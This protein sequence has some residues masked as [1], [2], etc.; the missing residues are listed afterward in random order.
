METLLQDLR[1][2]LRNMG[3][4]RAFTAI[5]ILVLALGIG[6]NTAMFSV[7]HGVLLRPLPFPQ[8]ERLLAVGEVDVRPQRGGVGITASYPD[9]FDFRQRTRTIDNLAA[10]HDS[11]YTLTGR[12]DPRHLPGEVVTSGFF[13]ALGVRPQLGRTF[14]REEEQAGRHVAILS[15]TLWRSQFNADPAIVGQAINLGERPYTVVGVMP[16][17]FQFPIHAEAI[18]LWTSIAREAESDTADKPVTTER[19]AHFLQMIGRLK[20]GVSPEQAQADMDSIARALAQQYPDENRY[21]TRTLL[22][23]VLTAIVG[24]R[25][26]PLLVLLGAVGLVLLIACANVANLLLARSTARGREIAIRAALGAT[27]GRIIRQLVTESVALALAGATLGT[28][29]AVWALAALVRLYP[30]NLPRLQQVNVDVPVL[31]FTVALALATGILFGLA[32]ALRV[33]RPDVAAAM[34]DGGRVSSSVQHNRLRSALVVAQTALGLMLLVGA[35]LLTRSFTRLTHVDPGL[36]THNVV[37]A[38]FGLPARYS[39]SEQQDQFVRTLFE[40]LNHLSGV[41]SAAGIMPLPLG[42]DFWQI[43]FEVEGRPLPPSEHLSAAFATATPGAFETLHIPLLRGR[44]FNER[45]QRTAPLVMIVNQAFAKLYYPGEDPIGKRL[46]PG[47][48]DGGPEPWR[49]IVGV[50][51]DVRSTGM[52]REP[53]P[54]YYLPYS[55]CVVNTPTIVLR[56]TGD[57]TTALAAARNVMHELD[58]QVALY[59]T[60][61]MEDYVALSVGQAKFQTVLF[62][63]F[64]AIALLLTAV[65]L[66]GVIAYTVVQ[67][68]HEIGIRMALGASR[69]HVLGLMMQ[70]GALLVG[71]GLAVGLAGALGLTRFLQSMLFA[72]HPEDPLTIVAVCSLLAVIALLASYIP[73]RRATKVDPLVTLRYE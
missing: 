26:T 59:G 65:G 34:K 10:Y 39:K 38:D 61:T 50:V 32:P 6:A 18:A 42:G 35:G 68:T 11:D 53:K 71:I 1:F 54:G 24:D 28:A 33:S 72:T 29:L 64:A 48:S 22:Q 40:R 23:P 46:K 49:E 70:H 20:D 15:D 7:I 44:T 63:I 14:L 55:Q 45:D 56:T 57:M 52:A 13:E 8:P 31:L 47:I 37:T 21:R 19:G 5:A 58:P 9:F 60:R 17:G 3:K 66:Y 69:A 62:G 73:A 41:A 43:S 27:A 36:D 12:G 30:S 2:A 16:P 25:R 67:R 4:A 51:G